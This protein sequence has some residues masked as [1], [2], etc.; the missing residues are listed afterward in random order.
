MPRGEKSSRRRRKF[1]LLPK[2]SMEV[3]VKT[4]VK[5]ERKSYLLVE[6]GVEKRFFTFPGKVDR[7]ESKYSVFR[8]ARRRK[9]LLTLFSCI[10]FGTRFPEKA[11]SE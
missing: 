11:K 7:Y 8:H 9:A 1:S 4:I 2:V 3:R 6:R 10:N 5:Y